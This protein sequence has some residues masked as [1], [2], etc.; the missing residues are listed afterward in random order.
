L[1]H[2][3][4]LARASAALAT[5]ALA[6]CTAS[7]ATQTLPGFASAPPAAA[8]S[9]SPTVGDYI[10]HVVIIIQENRSFD[11]LF[12]GFPGAD[13]PLFGNMRGH[14]VPL[15]VVH[16]APLMN[17]N[18][19]FGP[20]ITAWNHG[21]M[22]GF[23]GSASGSGYALDLPYAHLDRPEIQP[24]WDMASQYV[25]ADRMFPTEF[26]PSFTGHLSLIAGTTTLS[27]TKSVVNNPIGGPWGCDAVPG[28]FT[29]TVN[30][31]RQIHIAGAPCY[32]QFK[33][34]ATVLDA[35]GVSWKYYA[36]AF[37]GN[38][39]DKGGVLWSSFDAIK[40]VRYGSDWNSDIVS[41]QTQVLKDAAAGTLPSVSWVIPDWEWSDHPSTGTD[42][43]PSW[44]ADVVNAIGEGPDWSS[45]AIVVV[46]DDWGGWYDNVP[47]PH[48][49]YRGPGIRVGCIILS[50]YARRHYVSHT[51]YEFG[52]ILRFAE[53]AF[54]LPFIGP[55]SAGYTDASSRSLADSFDFTQ[56]PLTFAPIKAKY[57]P[58]FYLHFPPSGRPPDT[59]L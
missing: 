12:A 1:R 34:M 14:R 53:E 30:L 39:A 20:A 50:P 26:G 5:L 3:R 36:P 47:P 6:A 11:N 58:S 46:W 57:P 40:A 37:T 35:G 43:G 52:S 55:A 48:V 24:Y 22:D 54:G 59:D 4:F 45:T 32:D 27:P 44:V 15:H 38:D 2:D 41:P 31:E 23:S 10:K 56:T 16:F 33:T 49:G 9:S 28:T 7:G 18:H 13:A 25:L 21:R 8:S 29:Y 19:F 42:Y 51:E 17:V